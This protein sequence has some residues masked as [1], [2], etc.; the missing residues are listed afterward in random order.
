MPP[1][2]IYYSQRPIEQM[3]ETEEQQASKLNTN[4]TDKK[5]NQRGDVASEWK[6]LCFMQI[7]IIHY[8]T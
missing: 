2:V 3:L 7:W 4:G 8:H 6:Q 1:L 5:T